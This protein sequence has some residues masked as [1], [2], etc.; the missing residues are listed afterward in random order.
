MKTKV[1]ILLAMLITIISIGYGEEWNYYGNQ[2]L[3]NC[4]AENGNNLWVGTWSGLVKLNTITEQKTYYDKTNSGL[5]DLDVISVN[6]DTQGIIWIG[7]RFGGLCRFDGNTWTV[8]NTSNSDIPDNSI[9]AIAFD[10]Y[11][12]IWVATNGG[13]G[14]FSNNT[15]TT[16][17]ITN[18]DL[19]TNYLKCIT[20]DASG[21]KWIGTAQEL[22]T[23]SGNTISHVVTNSGVS[24][25]AIDSQGVI[26]VA[27]YSLGLGKL[28]GTT[29]TYYTTD[30]SDIPFDCAVLVDTDTNGNVWLSNYTDL[31]KFDGSAWT[32]WSLIDLTMPWNRITSI[33]IDNNSRVWIGIRF[34][35]IKSFNGTTWNTIS[36]SNAGYFVPRDINLI[37]VDY[38][39]RKWVGAEHGLS[40]FANNEWT[41]WSPA[42]PEGQQ[43]I[44]V[45]HV[46]V[47]NDNN[48]WSDS[49]NG[50][51]RD[52]YSFNGVDWT[53]HQPTEFGLNE[54]DICC[55]K[56]DNQNNKWIGTGQN[57]VRLNGA[58]FTIFNSTNSPINSFVIDVDR[59][60]YGNIWVS[61]YEDGLLHYNGAIW[62]S[63]NTSNSTIP[64]NSIHE[65]D[66]DSFGNKWMAT[67]SGLCR[68]DDSNFTVWNTQNSNIPSNYVKS[69]EIGSNDQVW[70]TTTGLS[71]YQGGVWTSWTSIN[72]PLPNDGVGRMT[73][74]AN[75][76]KWI[77]TYDG[78]Y[79][80]NEDEIV[81]NEDES[82]PSISQSIDI[83]IYP[84]PFL[85]STNISYN[86]PKEGFVKASIFNVKGQLVKI[87]INQDVK[88]GDHQISWDG[89]GQGGN[90]LTSGIYFIKIE[91][92][93]NKSI[94]KMILLK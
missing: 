36:L 38:L 54:I 23:V 63:Y 88:S 77:A 43:L 87:L 1:I 47:D 40:L 70:V 34:C 64:S 29:W 8:W 13:L 22:I 59:D 65:L 91:S 71:L 11:N 61:T 74:D 73:I 3:I 51:T 50:S 67:S 16:W 14:K 9:N 55:I 37:V 42:N 10:A 83:S 35:G 53:M 68:Y 44:D 21:T 27:F 7:T 15:W 75:G 92:N 46:A 90:K 20:I 39:N 94:K 30:N 2:N 41:T 62:T 58:G 86:L 26:W 80:F 45:A 79:V 28:S 52:L 66:I 31:T 85:L 72:S 12:N 60:L 32:T 19:P 81:A 33:T 69:V 4:S 17:N 82:L 84:N 5:P 6:I 56:A 93:E 18:S 76:N 78:V 25:I 49:D 57:L 89:I 48:V 24:A